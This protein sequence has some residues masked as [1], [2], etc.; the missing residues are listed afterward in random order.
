MPPKFTYLRDPAAIAEESL[1]VAREEADLSRLPGEAHDLALQLVQACGMP[2]ILNDLRCSQDAIAA[3]MAAL[4]RGAP[5]LCDSEMVAHG[6]GRT[7]LPVGTKV[8]CRLNHPQVASL[9]ERQG[10]NRAAAQVDLWDDVLD[11]AVVAIGEAPTALFRLLERLDGG[12]PRPALVI[13]FPCGLVGAADA[14]AELGANQ[15]GVPFIALAGR[16]GGSAL[17]AAAVNALARPLA[18]SPSA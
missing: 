5:I 12:A 15:L 6:I 11:G 16:R 7:A 9:A 8:I 1:R 4:R 3:G 13:G 14:K 10:S 17:A 2:D 18:S